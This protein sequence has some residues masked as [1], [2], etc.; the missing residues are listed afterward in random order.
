[1]KMSMISI[2]SEESMASNDSIDFVQ[3]DAVDTG[4]LNDAELKKLQKSD[5][6]KK[7]VD[8]LQKE[9]QKSKDAKQWRV[10]QWYMNLSFERGKQ[11]VAWDSTK[12]ALSTLPRGDKNLP[13]IIINKIRPII[14]TEIAK[15]TSQKPTAIC[16]PASN[17]VE[18][19][20]AA[21]AATQIWDSL[22]DRLEINKEMRKVARDISVLGLGYLK[23]FWNTEKYDEWS[24][25]DGDIDI[26]H[27]SPF[28]IFVPDLSITD[29][30]E[31]PYMLHV[32]TKP[33]EWLKMTYGDLI[34]KDKKPTVIAATE[35]ADIS[36][37]LD[38][39][40]NN[41]KPDASLIIEAWVKP[42]TTSMLPKGGYLVIVD[43]ILVEASVDGFPS[44]YKDY[45]IVKFEHIPSGQYYPACAIDD[46]IPLQ[47]EINRTRSQRI[48]SKNMMAKPQVY[49][50]EGS[51][52]VSKINTAPG[53]YIGVRPGFEYP[54]SAPLPQ[55]P[56]YVQEELN[57]LDSDLENIS[58]QHEVSRGEAPPGI[59]AATAIAYLQE[60]DDSYLAPTF[61]SIEEGLSKVAKFALMLAA[62][63][64]TGERTV[65][66]V[67]DNNGFSAEMFRGSDIARGTDI[68]IEAG[69]ALPTSKAAKQSL[70]M[71]MM[72]L[73][74]LPPEDGLELL[75]ISTL[76]GYTDNRGT[77]PD[78][79]RGQRENIMF[80]ALTEMAVMQHYQS[81]QQGVAQGNPAM[82]N[83]DTQAPLAP[84]SVIP[85]NK[86]DNHA[87]HIQEHDN[88]RKSPSYD[89]LSDSQKAE[90]NKHINMH[91]MALAA[92]QATQIQQM[93]MGVVP[94]GQQQPP[95]Q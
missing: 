80:K 24:E 69:S 85:V 47:R 65:K 88:F 28:N 50:R 78:E 13:R 1:M 45:P 44:G 21:K 62:E 11:Y 46:L 95:T 58:G 29:N 6:G 68:R 27:V 93:Q 22:Y 82:F 87:V 60:R 91:E 38:I 83:Q 53:Q 25:E 18:D 74:I 26:D 7:L 10:R 30:A 34:P 79:L 40:E 72:R 4:L 57:A 2:P 36:S 73:G 14:R 33:I 35:I 31:Q 41:S 56:N 43:D 3:E 77:R 12:S 94:P 16:L 63:F 71:D 19:V 89:L 48:Q 76:S 59:E 55:L 9:Y 20:F 49:Y 61:A 81:W 15:L 39:R 75:D 32:Y 5:K 86:W 52:S 70:V 84:P 23:V 42:G 92:L 64:W 54:A 90:L 66:V 37:A 51:L 17:D 8:Y 67:G